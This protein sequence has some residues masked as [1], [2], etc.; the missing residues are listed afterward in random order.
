MHASFSDY[1]TLKHETDLLANAT[2]WDDIATAINESALFNVTFR[3]VISPDD[4]TAACPTVEMYPVR[5]FVQFCIYYITP[6]K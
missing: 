5:K 2:E 1:E 6:S 4:T 3:T